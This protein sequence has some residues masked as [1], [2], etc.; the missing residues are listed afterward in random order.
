MIHGFLFS[1]SPNN[2]RLISKSLN[3]LISALQCEYLL[4]T[5]PVGYLTVSGQNKTFEVNVL[6]ICHHYL[7]K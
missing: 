6:D 5:I 2:K 7:S 4:K 1:L 3:S